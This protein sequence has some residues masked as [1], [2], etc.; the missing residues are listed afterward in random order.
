MGSIHH[1]HDKCFC[2]AMTDMRVARDFLEENLPENI[3]SLADLNTLKVSQDN[4]V[5]EAF[6]AFSSDVLYEVMLKDKHPAYFYLLL[7]HQSSVDVLM[8]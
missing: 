1:I 7:E 4:Y 6:E 5:D 2:K 3:Q 8:P